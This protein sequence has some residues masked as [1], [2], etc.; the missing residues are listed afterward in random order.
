MES[1]YVK[2]F[3][4][5]EGKLFGFLVDE[6]GSELF[7]H[8]SDGRDVEPGEP[9]EVKME[10]PASLKPSFP[11]KG[12]RLMFA[13]GKNAK[14]AK[15]TQWCFQDEYEDA[16]EKSKRD[17]T[18]DEAK[19]HLADKPCNVLEHTYSTTQYGAVITTI[20]TSITWLTSDGKYQAANAEFVT[21]TTRYGSGQEESK[22]KYWVSV[23][24][25]NSKY[26]WQTVFA[27][28]DALALKDVG[29]P[30]S[31]RK[32]KKQGILW[33][34]GW[35]D[36]VVDANLVRDMTGDEVAKCE[37]T[38]YPTFEDG[39][40]ATWLRCLFAKNLGHETQ[41]VKVLMHLGGGE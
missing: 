28:D 31:V 36:Y 4:T 23:H 32:G 30:Q 7:F 20:T 19:Q 38:S 25:P 13:R 15:A 12:D 1:G 37:K 41:V 26:S 10:D 14:G 35:E 2:F 11:R 5:R 21:T 9:G 3:D 39:K 27:G 6:K 24:A 17:L 22:S 29:K 34:G 8:Y 40:G 33:N 18:L 16:L